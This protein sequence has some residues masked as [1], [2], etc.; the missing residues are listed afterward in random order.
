MILER[1]AR[2]DSDG[3]VSQN[4]LAPRLAQAVSCP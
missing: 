2:A 3:R 4:E 1:R